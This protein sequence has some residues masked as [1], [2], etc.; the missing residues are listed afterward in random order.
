MS[1][2][3]VGLRHS[4]FYRLSSLEGGFAFSE[5]T[6]ALEDDPEPCQHDAA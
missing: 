3:L 1:P 4:E 2:E 6:P 5:E